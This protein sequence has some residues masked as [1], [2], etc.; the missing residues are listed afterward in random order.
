MAR[1]VIESTWPD[2]CD[3]GRSDACRFR[4]HFRT[5]EGMN[6]LLVLPTGSLADASLAVA[7]ASVT[8]SIVDH[9]IRSFLYA[10]LLADDADCLNDAEYNV[11]GFPSDPGKCY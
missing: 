2:R 10:R 5:F 6:Y 4:R 1:S 3:K 7:R 9:S 8:R 11:C